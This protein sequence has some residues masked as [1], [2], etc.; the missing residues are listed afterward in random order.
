LPDK[1]YDA[2]AGEPSFAIKAIENT[3][4]TRKRCW[5]MTDAQG[6]QFE[7]A[8]WQLLCFCHATDSWASLP[9]AWMSMLAPK[10]T[11]LRKKSDTSTVFIV[12]ETCAHNVLRWPAIREYKDKPKLELWQPSTTPDAA[13]TW[14]PVLD[15][16]HWEIAFV[17]PVGPEFVE[18]VYGGGKWVDGAFPPVRKQVSGFKHELHLMRS[19]GWL[20]VWAA[21][22]K[23][24]FAPLGDKHLNKALRHIHAV[25]EHQPRPTHKLEKVL[26]LM[27]WAVPCWT[28]DDYAAVLRR[29]VGLE[30]AKHRTSLLLQGN[31]LERCEGGC[32]D[33]GD[34]RDAKKYRDDEHTR[35]AGVEITSLQWLKEKGIITE[36]EYDNTMKQIMEKKKHKASGDP[37]PGSST[38][39]A[40][41]AAMPAPAPKRKIDKEDEAW[42][43]AN[44]L[45]NVSGCTI[46][47]DIDAN[48]QISW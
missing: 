1:K 33:R 21:A 39:A 47:H 27:K 37:H 10:G 30:G 17:H 45:P 34:Y 38:G 16:T 8:A 6:L 22:A 18:T 31:I 12:L 36:I 32:L 23:D 43:R 2:L 5:P 3:W 41:A 28:E 25:P 29:L 15:A 40:A 44:A 11:L 42:V 13:S 14:E 46:T 7:S 48:K 35:A 20:N 26:A 24:G 9:Y 4:T 19:S